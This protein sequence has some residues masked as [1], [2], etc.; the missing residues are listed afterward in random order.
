MDL[1]ISEFRKH[2]PCQEVK[3]YA[4]YL[5]KEH[6]TDLPAGSEQLVIYLTDRNR[7]CTKVFETG[8]FSKPVSI[9]EA[10]DLC[11]KD[12][13]RIL[14]CPQSGKE[15]IYSRKWQL[16]CSNDRLDFSHTYVRKNNSGI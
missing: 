13:A 6:S 4:V 14:C 5:E 3:D 11:F 2:F 10:K 15:Y 8:E 12:A 16:G 7:Y 9:L 1:Y